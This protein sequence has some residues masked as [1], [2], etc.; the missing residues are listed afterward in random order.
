MGA[1]ALHL[2]GNA[3]IIFFL[4]F[5]VYECSFSCTY[6]FFD[7]IILDKNGAVLKKEVAILGQK[8]FT[9]VIFFQ[10]LIIRL[11]NSYVQLKTILL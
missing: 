11:K 5:K 9:F 8:I 10:K 6:R 3:E 1:R 7:K 2:N 4:N